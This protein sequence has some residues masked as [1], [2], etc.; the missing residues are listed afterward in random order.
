MTIG[1]LYAIFEIRFSLLKGMQI[2]LKTSLNFRNIFKRQDRTERDIPNIFIG[3]G[4]ILL[5][6]PLFILFLVLS[7][8]SFV[9]S[10]LATVIVFFFG[11]MFSSAAA[12]MAGV[13]GSSNNPIS[14]ISLATVLTSSILLLLIFGKDYEFGAAGKCLDFVSYF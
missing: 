9:Y 13:V 1:A 3:I 11:F 8:F 4:L 6:I 7:A 10:L 2:G 5:I 14:G 12:Y